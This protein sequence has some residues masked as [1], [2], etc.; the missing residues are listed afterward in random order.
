M[1][2]SLDFLIAAHILDYVCDHLAAQK[3][4]RVDTTK[5]PK[6]CLLSLVKGPKRNNLAAQK[7]FR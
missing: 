4:Q 7:I 3:H 6:K 5:S 1:V 2:S